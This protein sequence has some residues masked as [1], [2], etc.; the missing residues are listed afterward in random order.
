VTNP[1]GALWGT[2]ARLAGDGAI[3]APIDNEILVTTPWQS[4]VSAAGVG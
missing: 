3:V 1:S 4:L 2:A